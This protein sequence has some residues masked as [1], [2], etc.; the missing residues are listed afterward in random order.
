VQ[1]Q[2]NGTKGVNLLVFIDRISNTPI[3]LLPFPLQTLQ[4]QLEG[5]G[6]LEEYEFEGAENGAAEVLQDLSEFHLATVN[7]AIPSAADDGP[8]A[9][10]FNFILGFFSFLSINLFVIFCRST[11]CC[12]CPLTE[13][14]LVLVQTL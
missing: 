12:V 14:W 1:K 2:L 5:G 11:D 8:L 3:H 6:S 13:H 7:S 10:A 4:N 9:S